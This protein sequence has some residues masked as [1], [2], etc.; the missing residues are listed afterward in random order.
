[1]FSNIRILDASIVKCP[2]PSY[3]DQVEWE[4]KREDKIGSNKFED[5]EHATLNDILGKKLVSLGPRG[6]LNPLVIDNDIGKAYDKGLTVLEE[7]FY[8]AVKK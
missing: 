5:Y 4:R 3:E 8:Q 1:M 6:R 7:L 2:L